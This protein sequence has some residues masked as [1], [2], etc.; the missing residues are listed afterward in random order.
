M[1][2]SVIEPHGFCAGVTAALKKAL[3]LAATLRDNPSTSLYCLHELV[4]NEIVVDELKKR[5]FSF[6]ESL[7]EVPDGAT[8]LF[9]AHGVSPEVRALAE[10][11]LEAAA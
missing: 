3:S 7:T 6:V 11:P 4:H 2:I 5:G 8:V 9:S 1:T 10:T